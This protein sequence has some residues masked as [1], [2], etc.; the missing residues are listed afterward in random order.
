MTTSIYDPNSNLLVTQHQVGSEWATYTYDALNRQATMRDAGGYTTNTYSVRSE[1][2]RQVN[3]GGYALS[4]SYDPVGNR[5]LLIDP[6][7]GYYPYAYDARNLTVSIRDP[8]GGFTTRTYDPVARPVLAQYP[9]Q[10]ARQYGYDVASQLLTQSYL[11]SANVVLV[12]STD[13]YDPVGNRVNRQQNGTLY[14]WTY[15]ASYQLLAQQEITSWGT[16]SY[17]GVGNILTKVPLGQNPQTFTYN[18]RNQLSAMKQ[19]SLITTYNYSSQGFLRSETLNSSVTTYT[20][21]NSLWLNGV[22]NSDGSRTTYTYR[23]D[24]KRRS[25]IESAPGSLLTTYIWDGDDYL[26][27]KTPGL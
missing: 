25:G 3:V 11:S 15:D 19:G 14:T 23:A 12:R 26:M 27:E 20:Y 18:V 8:R 16:F 13:T 21:T 10:T 7:N 6:D 2:T 17:D 1:L 22:R 5:S 9:N 24:G 4:N